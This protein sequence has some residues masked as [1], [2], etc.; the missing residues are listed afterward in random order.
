MQRTPSP[1][2]PSLPWILGSSVF[3]TPYTLC[4]AP[5][6]SCEVTFG[7]FVLEFL[8]PPGFS[9]PPFFLC[10]ALFIV[11][12]P[13]ASGSKCSNSCVHPPLLC[14]EGDTAAKVGELRPRHRAKRWEEG[15][16]RG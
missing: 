16:Q 14:L 2:S 9:C 13:S 6:P 11:L 10:P 1:P 5:T 4:L 7:V 8:L 12:F 15:S 3:D